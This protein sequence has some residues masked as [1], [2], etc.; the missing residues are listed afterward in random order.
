MSPLIRRDLIM[1]R[2]T[3]FGE[4]EGGVLHDSLG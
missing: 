1:D 3:V 4:L 2:H